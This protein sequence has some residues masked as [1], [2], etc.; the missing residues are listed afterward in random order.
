MNALGAKQWGWMCEWRGL[1]APYV[2]FLDAEG[3]V[4]AEAND[5][6]FSFE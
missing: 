6:V 3:G 2:F 4:K 5:G 1:T